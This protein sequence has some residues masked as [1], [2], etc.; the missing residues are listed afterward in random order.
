MRGC[1]T[2]LVGGVAFL[3]ILAWFALPPLAGAVVSTGLVASG[4][5]G[6]G[7]TV[8]V[9][10]SPPYE[11]LELHADAVEIHSTDVSWRGIVA[12]TLDLRLGGLDLGARTADSVSGRLDGV[13]V[14]IAGG[15]ASV[16]RMDLSGPSS[17]VRAVLMVDAATAN[18]L[19]TGAVETA[20]GKPPTSVQLVAPDRAVV[21]VGDQR[22][23]GTLGVDPS[24]AIIVTVPPFGHAVVADPSADVPLV[25]ESVSVAPGGAVTL[26]GTLD[27]RALGLS[28]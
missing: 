27:P 14:P 26:G 11:L 18:R 12:S 22:M 8:D 28:R 5:S 1:L 6:T 21:T 25:I 15:T 17:A 19:A 7:T 2:V 16:E 20:I 23:E 4:L 3:A 10:A 24:G 9:T 13:S